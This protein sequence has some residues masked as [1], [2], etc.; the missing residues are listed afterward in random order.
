MADFFCS[1]ISHE[2]GEQ[3]FGT[4][5]RIDVW[6]L[7][8]YAGRWEP[9][10][11]DSALP[12]PVKQTLSAQIEAAAPARF[13]LIRRGNEPSL[14]PGLAFYIALI[15][16]GRPALYAFRLDDM[17]DLLD[18]DLAA[19]RAEDPAYASAR[20]LDPMILVCTHGRRDRCCARRGL[21]VYDRLSQEAGIPVWQASHV[22]GHRFAANVVALPHGIYHG[23][24]T[25]ENA[26][27]VI[28]AYRRGQMHLETYRGRACYAQPVQAA[29]YYLR[30]E[31]GIL[32]LDGLA[33]QSAIQTAPDRWEIRF[34][35][36]HGGRGHTVQLEAETV[37]GLT[38][39]N[40]TDTEPSSVT[41]YRRV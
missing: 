8:E 24:V 14:A 4:A 36:T 6:F 30:S 2:A 27:S 28:D 34:A 41:Q 32:D 18:L 7:L 25:L 1:N 9:E 38:Y 23:R 35:E 21:P 15:R 13:G 20:T 16:E 37:P 19:I 10:A 31:T 12:D 39:L 5:P 17:H 26:V 11:L 33:L 29:E 3:L 40:C 22:G